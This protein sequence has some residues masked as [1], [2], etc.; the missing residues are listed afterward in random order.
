M[1]ERLRLVTLY[2]TGKYTVTELAR[3]FKVSRKTVHKWLGRFADEGIGGLDERS[4]A[5]HGHPRATPTPVVM[6]VV[7]A[8][9]AH[10]TYGPAKLQPGPDE[11]PEITGA[12]P[13]VST[14]GR[15]LGLYG[16]VTRRRRRRR[17]S[18]WFQPFLGADRPNSVW[19]ADFKG[20]IRT[21]DG[22]R[23]DPLTISDACTRMLLCCEILTKP[24]YAHVR[25]VFER[26]FREYGLPLAIRTDNGPP[27][28][29]VGAA[30]LSALAVWWVKLGVIPERIQPGHPEQNGR[31][32]RM[33]RT[34]KQAVM[35]P[36]AAN[37]EAQQERCD[38]Y[39]WE[40]NTVRPHQAL[41]QVPPANLYVPSPRLYP[42]RLGDVHYPPL[43]EVR[44]VRS[45]GQIK[46]HGELVFVSEALV[47]ELVGITEDK[48][49]WL[50]SFGPIPLGLLCPHRHS[51][52]PLPPPLPT[53]PHERSV[54]DVFS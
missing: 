24:D 38:G 39:R 4:R 11:P 14:R 22:T 54:T 37:P 35:N 48:D 28:A 23:C 40:Y 19:C 16:L 13:A 6:A 8:K 3:E 18:P 10:P 25:P 47:G 21:G 31:H 29:S 27:F 15:I 1:K 17:A 33:H 52:A 44:R 45:N 41:G 32:E 53:H 26:V 34:L 50:V 51:L 42:E 46:W 36:P 30:G 43:T 2:D 7:R 9:E 5:P 12:W 49:A 20:W